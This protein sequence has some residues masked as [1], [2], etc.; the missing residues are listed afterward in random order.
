MGGISSSEPTGSDD[1]P[2]GADDGGILTVMKAF[3][4]TQL[5]YSNSTECIYGCGHH[6]QWPWNF[7][8][9]MEDFLDVRSTPK[10]SSA[11]LVT[12]VF[13]HVIG[14]SSIHWSDGG[15]FY[16]GLWRACFLTVPGFHCRQDPYSA[17]ESYHN[18][19]A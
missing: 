15:V 14:F 1:E 9:S 8:G 2:V 13:V 10:L 3:P 6:I 5:D 17:G 7:S 12:A 19:C 16:T 18:R 4:E 11:V